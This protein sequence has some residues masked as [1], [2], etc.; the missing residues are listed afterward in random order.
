MVFGA[1][2]VVKAQIFGSAHAVELFSDDLVFAF[3]SSRMFKEM[4]H[5]K[6]HMS[7]LASLYRDKSDAFAMPLILGNQHER[8]ELSITVSAP[9][10]VSF[11]SCPRK[12]DPRE[13]VVLRSVT[14]SGKGRGSI[15]WTLVKPRPC[16]NLKVFTHSCEFQAGMM[17]LELLAK[18]VI[19]SQL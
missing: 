13:S 9:G 16:P 14:L 10:G 4:Q 3:I 12:F 1:P 15:T 18:A 2:D 17:V 8:R 11:C 5:A 7:F 19:V 6:F